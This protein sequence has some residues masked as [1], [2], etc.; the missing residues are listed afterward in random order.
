MLAGFCPLADGKQRVGVQASQAFMGV[1]GGLWPRP[2]PA[3]PQRGSVE[4]LG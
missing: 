1:R 3:G 4:S 2:E